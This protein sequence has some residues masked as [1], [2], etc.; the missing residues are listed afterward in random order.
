[1]KRIMLVGRTGAGKTSF[2]QI[3]QGQALHYQKTQDIQFTDQAIDTPGE[4]AENRRL[5]SALSVTAAE[6]DLVALVQDCG[7]REDIFSPGMAA[8]FNKPVIGIVTKTDLAA[9]QEE[10]N[11]ACNQLELAGCER[12]FTISSLTGQGMKGLM[13]YLGG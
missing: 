10:I 2:C 9:S 3:M 13:A 5:Y 6:A 8:M 11:H 7:S 12:I 4:Y 1:M